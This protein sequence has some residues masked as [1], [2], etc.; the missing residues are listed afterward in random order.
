MQSSGSSVTNM[1]ATEPSIFSSLLKI[2]SIWL[3]NLKSS[4]NL[5]EK[6]VTTRHVYTFKFVAIL[7]TKKGKMRTPCGPLTAASL[8]Q[9]PITG[10]VL[11]LP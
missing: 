8:K 4:L 3:K 1:S 9:I 7:T 2:S 10:F 11:E 5:M 6:N